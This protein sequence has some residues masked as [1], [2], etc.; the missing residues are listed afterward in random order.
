MK[1]L[2]PMANPTDKMKGRAYLFT[3]V[4]KVSETQDRVSGG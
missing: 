2:V 4:I 3:M 1:D